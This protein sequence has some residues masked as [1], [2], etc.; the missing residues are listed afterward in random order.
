VEPFEF[1]SNGGGGEALPRRVKKPKVTFYEV[2]SI[3]TLKSNQHNAIHFRNGHGQLSTCKGFLC[4]FSISIIDSFVNAF[5]NIVT[6]KDYSNLKI[7]LF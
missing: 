2:I 3:R 7:R 1:T 4:C 6:E 5:L